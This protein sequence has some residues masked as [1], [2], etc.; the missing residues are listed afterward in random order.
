[1]D[2]LALTRKV[3]ERIYLDDN[4]CIEVLEV[5]GRTVRLGIAAPREIKVYRDKIYEQI[6]RAREAKQEIS[7]TAPSE[8]RA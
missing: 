7:R 5:R 6:L 8:Y 4:I 1:M 2:M 3:G